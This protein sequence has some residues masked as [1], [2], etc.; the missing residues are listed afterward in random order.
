MAE[1]AERLIDCYTMYSRS[2]KPGFALL[3]LFTV[4]LTGTIELRTEIATE[5]LLAEIRSNAP[6]D[7]QWSAEEINQDVEEAYGIRIDMMHNYPPPTGSAAASPDAPATTVRAL[8]PPAAGPQPAPHLPDRPL[9]R[10]TRGSEARCT[11]GKAVG[12]RL[13]VFGQADLGAEMKNFARLEEHIITAYRDTETMRAQRP[14]ERDTGWRTTL[15]DVE[16][17]KIYEFELRLEVGA[18]RRASFCRPR[19]ARA[20]ACPAH[21]APSRSCAAG[22]DLRPASA[23][24]PDGW[25]VP[26][27]RR[28]ADRAACGRHAS[29]AGCARRRLLRGRRL[30][31]QDHT[32]VLQQ[33]EAAREQA[34]A[35][36]PDHLAL[37]P[38][39]PQDAKAVYDASVPSV[40]PSY[41]GHR[42]APPAPLDTRAG[43]RCVAGTCSSPRRR[44]PRSRSSSA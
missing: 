44:S 20:P 32:E 16:E 8:I 10:A 42:F 21:Y 38:A 11:L 34:A 30:H 22:G 12:T 5:S 35:D 25:R 6:A 40:G 26:P 18:C 13:R 3:T 36:V 1:V 41:A 29:R 28:V 31:R 2:A 24:R 15:K 33:M 7:C 14:A 9:R 37:Q 4:W 19:C 17:E 39:P 43:R 27:L 23:R